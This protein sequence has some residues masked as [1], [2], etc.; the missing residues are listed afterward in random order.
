[1][2]TW[3]FISKYT[4]FK[5]NSARYLVE[6]RTNFSATPRAMVRRIWTMQGQPRILVASWDFMMISWW[7]HGIFAGDFATDLTNKHWLVVT[8]TWLDYDFPYI[9]NNNPN[10]LSDFF[11]RGRYTTNQFN[12]GESKMEGLQNEVRLDMIW[13]FWSSW[14][15]WVPKCETETHCWTWVSTSV[16]KEITCTLLGYNLYKK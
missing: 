6:L 16:W 9:G 8:G 13:W 14:G 1:M 12:L 3:R 10:W 11:Q 2:F 7:F 5:R 4:I 15:Y